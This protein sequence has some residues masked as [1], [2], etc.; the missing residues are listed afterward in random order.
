[1]NASKLPMTALVITWNERHNI[2]ACLKA[3]RDLA[4][5]I[6]VVDMRSPDGTGK[7]ARELGARVVDIDRVSFVEPA[8]PV[9]I[10]EAMHD[11]VL[12]L[13]ADEV[14]SP[15]LAD[16]IRREV[17]SGESDL[18]HIPRANFALSGFAPHESEFPE[19][20]PRC[21]R[22]SSMDVEGYA[23]IIHTNIA[24]LPGTR[25][26]RIEG[27]WPDVCLVHLTNPTVTSFLGKI[28]GYTS[29]EA[30][31][32]PMPNFQGWRGVALLRIPL[33]RF[34][35]HW[36]HRRGSKDGWRG[37][38]L[39]FLFLVYEALVLMKQWEMSLHGGRLPSD[40][41]AREAMRKV[42]GITGP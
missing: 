38:W 9:A 16:A 8:R 40:E 7:R 34:W 36:R 28:N 3:V 22:R 6:L 4:E 19:Y 21:F 1:M 18:L 5:E 35:V 20:L 17:S 32:R 25:E 11:W 2:D 15:G 10:R 29:T 30:V 31:Q 42:A 13:D 39:S 41:E 23:G 37:F 24:P 33:R 12:V 26:R 27:V 14:V